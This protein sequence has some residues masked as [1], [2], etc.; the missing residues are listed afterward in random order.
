M[1]AIY[2]RLI[3][4][5]VENLSWKDLILKYDKPETFFY[6]DPPYYLCPDYKHNFVL[7]DFM[8]LAT[9]LKDIQGKFMLSI[10]DHSDIREVFKDFYH[11]EVSLFYTVGQKGPIEANELIYSNYEFKEIE[12]LSLFPDA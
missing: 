3:N 2:M 8:D 9:T 10:N 4:V 1:S 7:K 6:C 11:K 12:D 5:H